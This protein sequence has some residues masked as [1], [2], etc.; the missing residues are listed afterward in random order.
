MDV[1]L[2]ENLKLSLRK[3]INILPLVDSDISL[4]F[5]ISPLLVLAM[6]HTNKSMI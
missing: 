2:L 5:Y 3:P 1:L 4:S 6:C